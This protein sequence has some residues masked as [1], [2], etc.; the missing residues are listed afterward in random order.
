LLQ[1]LMYIDIIFL[2][3]SAILAGIFFSIITNERRR[4]IAVLRALGAERNFI[5]RLIIGEAALLALSG[6]LLGIALASFITSMFSSFISSSL[7]IVFLFP[8]LPDWGILVGLGA[9]LI[10]TTIILATVVPAYR[11]SR[12]EPALAARE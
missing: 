7:G 5:F 3:L 11:I 6:G 1:E 8:G 9:A 4:E 10:L 2:I 12:E